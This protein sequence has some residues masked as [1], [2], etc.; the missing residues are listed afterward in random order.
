M[1]FAGLKPRPVIRC[2]LPQK[3]RPQREACAPLGKLVPRTFATPPSAGVRD[4][5]LTVAGLALDGINSAAWLL[6]LLH[7]WEARSITG[8]ADMLFDL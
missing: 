5:P 1:V 4:L 6:W 7:D 8:R 3:I 2:I